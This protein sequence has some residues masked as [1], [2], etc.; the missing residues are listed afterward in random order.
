MVTRH[1]NT[2]DAGT[3]EAGNTAQA[4]ALQGLLEPAGIRIGGKR[5]WDVQI[6]DERAYG[7]ILRR[8]TL[9]AG[10]AYMRGWWDA[11]ALDECIQRIV[12]TR[13]DRRMRS[14][15]SLGLLLRAWLSNP[16]RVSRAFEI[17]EAHYDLGNDL[18]QAMLDRRL[19]YSCGYWRNAS[20][21]DLI[22]RKLGLKPGQRLLD[23]GCGWGSLCRYAAENY[24]VRAVGITVSAEQRR[25][26]QQ[27]CQGLP[28]EIRLQ[29]YR[30]L[31]EAFDHVASVGMLE[32]V[33]AGN[34][35]AMFETVRRCL[36]RDGLFLLHTIGSNIS[37]RSADPWIER[38]I[39][40]RGHLPSLRQIGAAVE[41][42]FVIEDLHNFG[43]DYD[44]TLM[45]WFRNFHASWDGL[46]EKYG[47]TFYRMWKFYLLSCAGSFRARTIQ[48]WQLVLSA[49]GVPG[50]YRRLAE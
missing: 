48:L 17:G 31:D 47:E 30:S 42:K 45:A 14:W 1:S 46:R 4:A 21:L 5:P 13:L 8:G 35:E 16:Q 26:A 49:D 19:V 18:F 44:R 2:I 43:A 6:L 33:G 40:P 23:I 10:E 24:G 15:R 11:P 20:E 9:G 36:R 34:Y 7:Q 27:L 41:R 37:V 28:I 38:F 12:A 50:G 39:F 29:D 22:C 3:T 32:H 25:L